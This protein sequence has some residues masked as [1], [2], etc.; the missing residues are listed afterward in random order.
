MDVLVMSESDIKEIKLIEVECGIGFWSHKDYLDELGRK[1][2]LSFVVK[3]KGKVA[4]FLVARLITTSSLPF[5]HLTDSFNFKEETSKKLPDLQKKIAKLET[6]FETEIEIY[7]IAI[8]PCFQN[9]GA[10]QKL[11]DHLF[12][13]TEKFRQKKIWL[14]VRKSNFKAIGFYEKNG[15]RRI[16][17][18]RNFYN[19]PV[20]NAIVMRKN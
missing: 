10:G 16:Y 15:F 11:I 12:A 8:K 9:R 2:S 20:E 3:I 6:D 19:N 13:S 7:N 14:E 1:D 17:E 18:R 5:N 4:G